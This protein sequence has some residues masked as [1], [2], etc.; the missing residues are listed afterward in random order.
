VGNFNGGSGWDDL[1]VS[2][3]EW[4]GL[5]RSRSSSVQNDAIYYHWIHTVEYHANDWW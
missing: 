1:F 2:N 4:F 5:L 3:S